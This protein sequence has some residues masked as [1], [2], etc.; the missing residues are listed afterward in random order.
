MR[1]A[2]RPGKLYGMGELSALIERIDG[3]CRR[4]AAASAGA[5]EPISELEDILSEGY[6][7]ALSAESRSRRLA[8]RL[9]TLAETVDDPRCAIEVRELALQKRTVDQRV[10]LLRCALRELR[11]KFAELRGDGPIPA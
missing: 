11:D 5:R 2:A 3:H 6:I 10:R 8:D 4:V 7:V 9:A 1:P